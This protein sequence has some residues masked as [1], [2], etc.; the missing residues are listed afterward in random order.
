[1]TVA[2]VS[3]D[4][5]S[6]RAK[7]A[8]FVDFLG[9]LLFAVIAVLWLRLHSVLAPVLSPPP[10]TPLHLLV[11]P[12]STAESATSIEARQVRVARAELAVTDLLPSFFSIVETSSQLAESVSS[13][14]T[15]LSSLLSLLL[16]LLRVEASLP[17]RPARSAASLANGLSISEMNAAQKPSRRRITARSAWAEEEEGDGTAQESDEGEDSD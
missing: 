13:K 1:M 9:M 3:L 15:L 7:L 8:A 17:A 16:T 14:V 10:Y 6:P 11:K 12:S 5:V 4:S 2:H